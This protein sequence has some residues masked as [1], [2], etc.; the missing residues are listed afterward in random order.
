MIR[1][2]ALTRTAWAALRHGG[3]C[4]NLPRLKM[5]RRV[6]LAATV[7]ALLAGIVLGATSLRAEVLEYEPPPGINDANCGSVFAEDP[8][9]AGDEGC[10][11]VLMHRFGY[12]FMS[13]FVAFIFGTISAIL[14]F[15]IA[16]RTPY[17]SAAPA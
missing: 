4:P 10:E 13:F 2:T 7:I 11:R 15:T 3:Y 8:D 12:V 17:T 14:M 16:R 6:T 1:Y 9:W 5:L